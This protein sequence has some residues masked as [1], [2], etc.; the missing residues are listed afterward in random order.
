MSRVLDWK[1]LATLLLHC[2]CL[3]DL[4]LV[5][6]IAEFHEMLTGVPQAR[7]M[8]SKITPILLKLTAAFVKKTHLVCFH[9]RYIYTI[10]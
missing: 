8:D 3:E 6:I 10:E 5:L 9:P 7:E 2:H 1:L 4:K